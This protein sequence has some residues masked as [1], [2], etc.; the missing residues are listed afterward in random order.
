MLSLYDPS[1]LDAWGRALRELATELR[2][3]LHDAREQCLPADYQAELMRELNA[4]EMSLRLW[5]EHLSR[6]SCIVRQLGEYART[7]IAREVEVFRPGS[8]VAQAM[9][10][11]NLDAIQVD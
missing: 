11:H 4:A 3:S 10:T 6:V 8:D 2:R 5:A 1:R 9:R 7:R